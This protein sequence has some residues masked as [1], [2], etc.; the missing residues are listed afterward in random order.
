MVP[1]EPVSRTALDS[2]ELYGP[3]M[4][5]PIIPDQILQVVEQA[6]CDPSDNYVVVIMQKGHGSKSTLNNSGGVKVHGA[7]KNHKGLPTTKEVF[8]NKK[9]V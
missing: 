5:E 6:S 7:K 9:E 3:R 4:V 1:Q 8:T 2:I